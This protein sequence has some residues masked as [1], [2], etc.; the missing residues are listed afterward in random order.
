MATK[1]KRL[2][3]NA[4]ALRHILD[5]LEE[6]GSLTDVEAGQLYH[7]RLGYHR[8]DEVCSCCAHNGA[9]LLFR[10]AARRLARAT[11]ISVVLPSR[12]R[13]GRVGRENGETRPE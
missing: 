4:T 11:E 12:R 2:P 5:V 3:D 9:Q 1:A 7:E 6:R 8:G 10:L 13:G